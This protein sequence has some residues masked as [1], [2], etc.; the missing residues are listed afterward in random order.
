MCI[1]TFLKVALLD[2]SGSPFSTGVAGFLFAVYN[3]TKIQLLTKFLL[4][5][6]GLKLKENFQEMIHG[7]VPF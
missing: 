2:I 6:K 4:T 3:S 7:G 1:G 5:K